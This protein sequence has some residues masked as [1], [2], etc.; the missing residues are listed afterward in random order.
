M[1]GPT[2]FL[3]SDVSGYS[4]YKKGGIVKLVIILTNYQYF[5]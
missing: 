2:T 3:I 5:I 1:W 4:A